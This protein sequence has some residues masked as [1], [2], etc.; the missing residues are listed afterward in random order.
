[1]DA[2]GAERLAD[3]AAVRIGQA[4]VED[5]RVDRAAA[6]RCHR[7]MAGG[8]RPRPV[9]LALERANQRAAQIVVVLADAHGGLHTASVRATKSMPG[10][11]DARLCR[12]SRTL[13]LGLTILRRHDRH[14]PAMREAG[15][16]PPRR[17]RRRDEVVPPAKVGFVPIPTAAW[18]ASTGARSTC[19]RRAKP[20]YLHDF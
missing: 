6:E 16:L 13:Q 3:V 5:Q 17:P 1:M 9:A 4:D 10:Q 18:P 14:H 11:K 12:H 7:R 2:V 8:R 15:R 19:A 20:R